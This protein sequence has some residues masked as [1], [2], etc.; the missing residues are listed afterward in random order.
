M[1]VRFALAAAASLALLAGP[2]SAQMLKLTLPADADGDGVVTEEERAA[3]LAKSGGRE[4][5]PVYGAAPPRS[6][7]TTVT[8]GTGPDDFT[9]QPRLEDRAVQASGFEEYI[10]EKADRARQK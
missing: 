5:G 9:S 8:F 4:D 6:G 7:D 3:H 2:A 1:P 10:N